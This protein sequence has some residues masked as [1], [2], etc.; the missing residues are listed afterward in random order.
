MLRVFARK[1][2]TD[3]ARVKLGLFPNFIF[4]HQDYTFTNG[5]RE[6]AGFCPL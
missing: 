6:N 5:D 2:S 1:G 4:I 3:R